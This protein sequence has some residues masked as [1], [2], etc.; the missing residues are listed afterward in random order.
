MLDRV[1]QLIE[2]VV[3]PAPRDLVAQTIQVCAHIRRD[4][5]HPAGRRLSGLDRVCGRNSDGSW[6]L[7]RIA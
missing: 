3:Y 6:K 4:T 2:E 7:E 5:T 1:C